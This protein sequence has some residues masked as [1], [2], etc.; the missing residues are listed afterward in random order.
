[1]EK[2]FIS[3]QI[4][5]SPPV[6]GRKPRTTGSLASVIWT[7]EVPSIIPMMAISSRV[8]GSVQPHESE[9]SWVEPSSAMGTKDWRSIPLQA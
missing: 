7:K 3:A 4:F 6:W 2:T 1:M 8:S 9:A 5:K